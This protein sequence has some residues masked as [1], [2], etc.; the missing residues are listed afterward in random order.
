MSSQ[1]LEKPNIAKEEIQT[2]TS[3]DVLL[4][5]FQIEDRHYLDNGT[6]IDD[7]SFE[8]TNRS[9]KLNYSGQFF[10]PKD[11]NPEQPPVVYTTP[12]LTELRGFNTLVG[13]E[14]AKN[15][16]KAISLS[17]EHPKIGDALNH[18]LNI[19]LNKEKILERDATSYS[20]LL[21]YLNDQKIDDTST[22]I[23]FGYSRGSMVGI[24]LNSLAQINRRKIIYNE[25]IDLCLKDS[26]R[27]MHLS[28]GELAINLSQEAINGLI[29]VRK[30]PI[31]DKRH[32]LNTISTDP[33]SIIEHI[34]TGI[35]LF[36]GETGS[37]LNNIPD[38]MTGTVTFFKSSMFNQKDRWEA[39][40]NRF[41]YLHIIYQNGYH[42]SGI[43]PQIIQD[44]IA[45]IALFQKQFSNGIDPIKAINNL[46][47]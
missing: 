8:V 11:Y 35:G 6:T 47:K 14:L 22:I 19:A 3:S 45:R 13:K 10:N 2:P 26:V 27:S 25:F 5:D 7:F 31:E 4:S 16:L 41:P 30:L 24:V 37:F 20:A 33:G 44:G 9:E 15:G 18:F 34:S 1:V 28:L 36:R 21:E 29:E 17:P 46:Y 38:N 40:L 43:N 42:L 39:G 23:L 12:W 32:L